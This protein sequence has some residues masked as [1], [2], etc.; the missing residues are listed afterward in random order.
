MGYSYVASWDFQLSVPTL[1]P[2]SRVALSLM[3]GL[4]IGR[5]KQKCTERTIVLKGVRDLACGKLA[6]VGEALL[7]E[8]K[9]VTPGDTGLLGGGKLGAGSEGTRETA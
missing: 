8:L 6:P 2:L 4:M 3:E 5:R 7:G 1:T 9:L